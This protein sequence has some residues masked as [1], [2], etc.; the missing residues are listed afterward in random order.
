MKRLDA[1]HVQLTLAE[2]DALAAPLNEWVV[3]GGKLSG[4]ESAALSK[5]AK[6]LGWT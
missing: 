6:L 1:N 5:A 3:G 4:Q 2:L